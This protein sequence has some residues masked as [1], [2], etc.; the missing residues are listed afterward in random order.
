MNNL[1]LLVRFFSHEEV[2]KKYGI[3]LDF[4]E[5]FFEGCPKAF[6][7]GGSPVYRESDVDE[8]VRHFRAPPYKHPSRRKGGKPFANDEIAAF[9]ASL[10]D[11]RRDWKEVAAEVN[12]EFPPAGNK[13]RS[14]DSIRKLVE[15]YRIRHG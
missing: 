2:V 9:A 7:S 5:E 13:K 4:E 3:N 6:L 8:Y 15:R 14:P 1:M 12:K 11:E 10:R